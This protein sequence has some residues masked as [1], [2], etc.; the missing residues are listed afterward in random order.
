ML[1]ERRTSE[2]SV[3]AAEVLSVGHQSK[4]ASAESLWGNG[5]DFSP[6][7]TIS[8]KESALERDDLDYSMLPT[9][10]Y[11]D[12]LPV[13]ELVNETAI[14]TNRGLEKAKEW[15]NRLQMQDIMTIGD[16]RDLH[17]EDWSN[18]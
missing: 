13:E 10:D 3:S 4:S 12:D 2:K 18:L 15:L 1:L 9:R 16:L 14:A 5:K 8:R 17:D 6:V 7:S 11:V